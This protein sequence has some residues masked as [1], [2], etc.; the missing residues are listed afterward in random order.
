MWGG[1]RGVFLEFELYIQDDR[2]LTV[3]VVGRGRNLPSTIDKAHRLYRT[4]RD[5]SVSM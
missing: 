1:L 4:S 3:G 2:P 5:Q